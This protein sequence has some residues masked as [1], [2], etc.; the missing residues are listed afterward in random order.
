MIKKQP[1][2]E[3]SV[4]EFDRIVRINLTGT[5]IID[6][7]AGRVTLTFADGH[8]PNGRTLQNMRTI[9]VGPPAIEA[10]IA[11]IDG[12]TRSCVCNSPSRGSANWIDGLVING[13]GKRV[14]ETDTQ[15]AGE[16]SSQRKLRGVIV[17]I[18]T[19]VEIS[20]PC[21]LLI[22]AQLQRQGVVLDALSERSRRVELKVGQG[23]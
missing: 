1:S 23:C 7:A 19:I 18:T 5:F 21:E 2:L 16:P 6:Q 3:M 8:F 13:F 11:D 12:R 10:K 4:A 15:A 14:C 22:R 9:K 17:R 20:D